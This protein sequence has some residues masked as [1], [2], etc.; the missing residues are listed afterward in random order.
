MESDEEHSKEK[1]YFV[2][3][4][5]VPHLGMNV[6]MNK[7]YIIISTLK[8]SRSVSVKDMLESCKMRIVTT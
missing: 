1:T 7:T 3:S 8:V 4:N 6:T 2:N 5:V